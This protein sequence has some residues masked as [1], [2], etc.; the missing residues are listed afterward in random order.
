MESE[1]CKGAGKVFHGLGAMTSKA[2]RSWVVRHLC[3]TAHLTL[4]GELKS[5]GDIIQKSMQEPDRAM[6]CKDNKSF[7]LGEWKR[8]LITLKV[9]GKLVMNWINM[10]FK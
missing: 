5:M 7:E 10:S 3:G 9:G 6:L 2:T 1:H 4:D 8:L